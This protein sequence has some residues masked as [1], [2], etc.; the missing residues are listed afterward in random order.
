MKQFETI[1]LFEFHQCPTVIVTINVVMIQFFLHQ[2]NN[3][4]NNEKKE[5]HLA[6]WMLGESQEVPMLCKLEGGATGHGVTLSKCYG[7]APGE[8]SGLTICNEIWTLVVS[9]RHLFL[10]SHN[11]TA[12]YT[13]AAV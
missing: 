1:C 13:Q 3:V 2:F 12:L 6:A 5:I 8:V 4:Y 7:C 9:Q 10:L 11:L